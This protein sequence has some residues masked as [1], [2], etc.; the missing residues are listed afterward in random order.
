MKELL[1]KQ[2]IVFGDELSMTIFN[3]FFTAGVSVGDFE[4]AVDTFRTQ[5]GE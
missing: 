5:T 2:Y 1:F 3:T 4:E